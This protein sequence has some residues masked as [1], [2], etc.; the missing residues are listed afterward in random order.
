MDVDIVG[1]S[2]NI[3]STL[4]TEVEEQVNLLSVEVLFMLID[5]WEH[6]VIVE[7]EQNM[8][9]LPQ[10]RKHYVHLKVAYHHLTKAWRRGWSS[11]NEEQY[12][13]GEQSLLNK[14]KEAR[15]EYYVTKRRAEE[16]HSPNCPCR[17]CR[18]LREVS[19]DSA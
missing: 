19:G 15:V 13:Q 12:N 3:L 16:E 17:G 11:M 6:D 8:Y 18:L 14:I 5:K 9:H 4:E 1:K 2:N 7:R 10:A